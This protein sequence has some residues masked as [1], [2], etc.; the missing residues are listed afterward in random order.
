MRKAVIVLVSLAVVLLILDAAFRI[1]TASTE[2]DSTPPDIHADSNPSSPKPEPGTESGRPSAPPTSKTQTVV[3]GGGAGSAPKTESRPAPI[4]DSLLKMSPEQCIRLG[5]NLAAKAPKDWTA[6][7]AHPLDG[8]PAVA[9]KMRHVMAEYV[10]CRSLEDSDPEAVRSFETH[11]GYH[12]HDPLEYYFMRALKAVFFDKTP[13][14]QFERI[15]FDYPPEAKSWM[16][17]IY[18]VTK[19]NRDGEEVCPVITGTNEMFRATCLKSYQDWD[20]PDGLPPYFNDPGRQK[21]ARHYY[22]VQKAII[23]GG[24]PETMNKI[25][26]FPNLSSLALLRTLKGEKGVCAAVFRNNWD[27]ICS[28]RHHLLEQSPGKAD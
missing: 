26:E 28:G 24:S 3:I 18:D 15:V 19:D 25:R 7:D 16:L 2:P 13:R 11:A 6:E 21:A 4:G 1:Y 12:F 10:L 9:D 23:S 27:L 8:E 22:Y 17:R 20:D 5:K 14:D